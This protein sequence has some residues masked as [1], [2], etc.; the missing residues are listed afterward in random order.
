MTGPVREGG[1]DGSSVHFGVRVLPS[2]PRQ[3][4]QRISPILKGPTVPPATQERDLTARTRVGL[5]SEPL[6]LAGSVTV[7]NAA[8][9][10]HSVPAARRG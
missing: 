7:Q 10:S 9:L 2:S 8:A 1:P 5:G 6:T 3:E 4:I